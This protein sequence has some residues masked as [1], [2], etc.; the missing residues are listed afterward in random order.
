MILSRNDINQIADTI[1]RDF[2]GD[3]RSQFPKTDIDRLAETYLQLSVRYLPLSQDKS[4]LGL[5]SY[6]ET[7]LQLQLEDHTDEVLVKPN[8]VL[9][10]KEFL[11]RYL[12][13]EEQKRRALRRR[14]TLAHECAHQILFRLEPED[15]KASMRNQYSQYKTY[16]CYD[17]K[18]K[19]DWN[20]W[21]AN[22]LGAALLIPSHHVEKYFERYQ[23]NM[24]LLC[25]GG[26]YPKREQLALSHL[27]G[28]FGVTQKTMEIRLK[29]L[30]Y[31]KELPRRHY[32]DP[33]M[34]IAD[35]F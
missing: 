35:D 26:K 28:F 30:G 8:S 18:S 9:L 22:T 17:L 32:F 34:I 2:Q 14:F 16:D 5:T 12:K 20:E 7:V 29:G 21:Q 3:T 11:R 6:E 10:E 31:L 24:P 15:V 33:T 25:Y 13:A 1:I 4:L 23:G 27:T 19:E